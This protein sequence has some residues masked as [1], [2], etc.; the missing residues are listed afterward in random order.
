MPEL[1]LQY[2]DFSE[3][4][5]RELSGPR[6]SDQRSYWQDRFSDGVPR[7][8]LP[9]DRLRPE[10]FTFTGGLHSFLLSSELTSLLQSFN[11]QHGG[12]LQM[13]LLTVL[14]VLFHK[15]TGQEDI[16]IGC[17]IA[18]RRHSDLE[19]IVGMFVNSL[20]MRNYPSREK[21]F[22][23][24]YKEV[25]GSSLEAYEHQEMQ[26]EDLVDMLK[27]ERDASRNPIF[28]VALVVQNYERKLVDV[29]VLLEDGDELLPYDLGISQDTSKFDMTWFVTESGGEISVGIEYYASV[30]DRSTIIRMSEHFLHL[31]ESVLRLPDLL[32]GSIR[33]PDASEESLLL[34][35]YVSGRTS[36]YPLDRTLDELF[37]QQCVSAPLYTAVTDESCSLS[38][39]ELDERSN[40]LA[41]FLIESLSVQPESRIGLLQSRS[42]SGVVSMLGVLKAGCAYVPLDS[43]YPEER[44]LYMLQDAG[45]SV[46]LT[47]RVQIEYGN[48]LQ[49]RSSVDHVV[50]IDSVDYYAE[51]GVSENELMR[52][53]LWDHVGETSTDA[54]SGGGWMSSYTGSYLSEAEMG[55]YSENVYLKL[56][57]YLS[58]ETRVLE[59]GCSSGLT[60]LRLAGDVGYYHGTDLS[61]RILSKTLS[62]VASSGYTNI[63]LEC[64]PA[65][66][67]GG[68]A[69]GDFDIVIINSVIQ[70]FN[71]HNYLRDVVEQAIG[72]LK[73]K[74]LLFVGDI[75]DEDRREALISDLRAFRQG[76]S[77]SDYRTK[78]DWS[79]ELFVGRSYWEDLKSSGI[80]ITSGEYSEKIHTISNELTAYRYDAL[81]WVDKQNKSLVPERHKYQHDQGAIG[82]Y[83]SAAVSGYSRPSGLAYV[84][85]TS[86][87]TGQPKGVMIEHRNVI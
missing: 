68:I 40:Q 59:I 14:N 82:Q 69:A 46:L 57:P 24:F 36:A 85:Y 43:D 33:L 6:M 12:T 75:M 21:T 8:N 50:C 23:S 29:S 15:Y 44:L 1:R 73:D 79:S 51:R 63:V 17:G 67:I 32:I 49:W 7:L 66:R 56:R 2:R 16:V 78:T 60:M 30:Y 77:G 52:K 19:P 58:K 31:L 25:V 64:V 37:R 74:G 71:G 13:S 62:G 45:V 86:G 22:L 65:D 53:D 54:I 87:S 9:G 42:C 34:S 81:L 5:N 35:E 3:W 72:K 41:R 61:D 20:A 48:R 4:Q 76:H 84:I 47:E 55:E 39:K 83:S 11:L 26:F 18:G 80:G 70:A 10:V 27:I 38:Y 28:D